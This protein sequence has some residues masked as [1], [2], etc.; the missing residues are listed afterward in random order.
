MFHYVW[1]ES[2]QH[3][4]VE[5]IVGAVPSQNGYI[6]EVGKLTTHAIRIDISG[7]Q[8]ITIPATTTSGQASSGFVVFTIPR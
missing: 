4:D 8:S 7:G 5:A 3:L 1:K 6:I 2:P